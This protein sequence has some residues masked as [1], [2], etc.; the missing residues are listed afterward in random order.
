MGGRDSFKAQ[1]RTSGVVV[2]MLPVA[3]AAILSVINPDYMMLFI[4]TQA[5]NILI[6]V[7]V[8]MEVIGFI[9][10]NRIVNIKF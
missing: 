6:G 2:G 10:I 3:L 4:T 7:A 8:V 9:V 5:G 1:G